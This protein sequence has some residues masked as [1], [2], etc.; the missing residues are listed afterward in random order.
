MEIQEIQ[1]SIREAVRSN[2]QEQIN[3]ANEPLNESLLA[4]A[5]ALGV[6]GVG[7]TL[8]GAFKVFSTVPEVGAFFELHLPRHEE[9]VKNILKRMKYVKSLSDLEIIE[10]DINNYS[11]KLDD[12]KNKVNSIKP[13]QI[14][15]QKIRNVLRSASKSILRKELHKYVDMFKQGFDQQIEQARQEMDDRQ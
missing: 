7:T 12:L 13:E 3:G 1:E 14:E 15:D 6:A 5:V 2:I 4:V 9:D 11:N 10:K 8:Y